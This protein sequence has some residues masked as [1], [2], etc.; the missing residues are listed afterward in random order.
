MKRLLGLILTLAATYSLKAFE[1]EKYIDK[2]FPV[3]MEEAT[4]TNKLL[5]V[6]IGREAC[7]NCIKFYNYIKKGE[8]KLDENKFIYLKLDI[9]NYD[10]QNYFT[11]YFSVMG[12]V[13]PFVGVL[14]GSGATFGDTR[15]G[16]G[17]PEAYQEFIQRALDDEKSWI[18]KQKKQAEE[19]AQLKA[20]KAA[21]KKAE[22]Q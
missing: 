17:T 9:D 18:E 5:F 4:K 22:Q 13:L 14:N 20:A 15:T 21:R 8:L 3:Y 16:F 1:T 2:D 10:H 11:S 7:S 6:S 19:E 12:N